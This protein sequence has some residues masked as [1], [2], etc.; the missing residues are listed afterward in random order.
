MSLGGCN[1]GRCV[2]RRVLLPSIS[3][4]V[5]F[6][7]PSC[8]AGAGV[9]AWV[10]VENWGRRGGAKTSGAAWLCRDSP[11]ES[12]PNLEGFCP[13]FWWRH[14]KWPRFGARRYPR[15]VLFLG[16]AAAKRAVAERIF[17]AF[18]GRA[19]NWLCVAT[20]DP[21][22]L[23]GRMGDSCGRHGRPI[24]LGRHRSFEPSHFVGG[25]LVAA[26]RGTGVSGAGTLLGNCH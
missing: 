18:R 22:Q 24:C 10:S 5:P 19:P 20:G 23:G 3:R 13:A 14:R 11:R 25:P 2:T 16:V 1:G 15:W 6:L 26:L 17:P 4:E 7:A 9:V 8:D 12:S 21:E